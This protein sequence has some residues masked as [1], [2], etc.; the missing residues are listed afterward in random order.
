MTCFKMKS[1]VAMFSHCKR[2]GIGYYLAYRYADLGYTPE[3]AVE[4]AKKNQG[5]GRSLNNCRHFLSDGTS[6]RSKCI[7]S[8]I[9]HKECY[10]IISTQGVSP[11][12]AFD[13]VYKKAHAR[14]EAI[15]K[16]KAF[17]LPFVLTERDIKVLRCLANS[18]EPL[19]SSVLATEALGL[20]GFRVADARKRLLKRGLIECWPVKS[21]TGFTYMHKL[22]PEYVDLFKNAS[23]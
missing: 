11:E 17:G 23:S 3:E 18:E 4:L 22:K 14:K 12:E 1:G 19:T 6:L 5:R 21:L 16:M 7:A 10:R 15:S 8:K 9:D 13:I 2:R 20:K